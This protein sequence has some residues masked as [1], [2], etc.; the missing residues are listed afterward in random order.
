ME[1]SGDAICEIGNRAA[2]DRAS[3]N[4]LLMATGTCATIEA[5]APPWLTGA[6]PR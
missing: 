1:A 4:V 6:P 5:L 3:A 2:A